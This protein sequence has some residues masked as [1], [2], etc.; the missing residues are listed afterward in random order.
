MMNAVHAN[1]RLFQQLIGKKLR[2]VLKELGFPEVSPDVFD[3]ETILI[4][5][6]HMAKMPTSH[7]MAVQQ[8]VRSLHKGRV[9][10]I[11]TLEDGQTQLTVDFVHLGY[12][13]SVQL[14]HWH[15]N[16]DM[17]GSPTMVKAPKRT[18]PVLATTA[19]FAV[20]LLGSAWIWSSG[21]F[22]A[23]SNA[24]S[25]KDAIQYI[26]AEGYIVMTPEEK[27]E[28][29]TAAEENGYE[30]ARQKLA[31][32]EETDESGEDSHTEGDKGQ[33]SSADDE[34]E[35]K[36]EWTFTMKEGMTSKDVVS[37]LKEYGLIEDE[38]AFAQKLE[39]A[40]IAT[41][42]RPGKYTFTSDMSEK[43][44]MQALEPK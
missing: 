6:Q 13:C 42:V 20:L 1:D 7:Q 29:V 44:I 18:A 14:V 25:V 38:L 31:K 17:K 43:E 15:E 39:D 8:L 35:K 30:K 16:W 26:E 34:K 12:L 3:S 11:Q 41:K 28:M 5:Q 24:M 27:N 37:A 19:V 21:G 22:G 40:G 23:R 10:A 9:T 2:K 36:K 33:D 32:Q 4:F